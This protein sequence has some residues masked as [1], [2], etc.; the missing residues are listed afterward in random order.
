M[1]SPAACQLTYSDSP[2]CAG[3]DADRVAAVIPDDSPL[4]LTLHNGFVQQPCQR[5]V[6]GGAQPVANVFGYEQFYT[7]MFGLQTTA[8]SDSKCGLFST[9]READSCMLFNAN[10][11]RK[12]SIGNFVY[13]SMTFVLNP[14]TLND[15]LFWEAFDGGLTS[16]MIADHKAKT[17]PGL[18]SATH[19]PPSS[20]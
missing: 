1:R 14:K 17:Y 12:T 6:L 4:N 7:G 20:R 16:L 5:Y 3:K 9:L 11:L 8:S 19:L 13:G 18:G 10:N 2:R 15:R